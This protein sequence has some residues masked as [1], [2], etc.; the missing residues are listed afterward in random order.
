[1]DRFSQLFNCGFG[2]YDETGTISIFLFISF[3]LWLVLVTLTSLN[4]LFLWSF[5]RSSTRKD[6]IERTRPKI[7]N[8]NCAATWYISKGVS[9]CI[10]CGVQ[11]ELAVNLLRTSCS[12]FFHIPV[13]IHHEMAVLKSLWCI[14]KMDRLKFTIKVGYRIFVLLT[15]RGLPFGTEN[16]CISQNT[17]SLLAW[18]FPN[19]SPM[20]NF[21]AFGVLGPLVI[22]TCLF[23]TTLKQMIL[24]M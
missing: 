6:K 7:S 21:T 19:F 20:Q 15:Y 13:A 17:L 10:N 5:N 1:M 16:C 22:T 8:M 9:S 18:Q 11:N 2:G 23:L 14:D 3:F 24:Y 4:W 12:I